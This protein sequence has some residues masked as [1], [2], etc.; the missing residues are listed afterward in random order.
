MLVVYGNAICGEYFDLVSAVVVIHD[1]LDINGFAQIGICGDQIVVLITQNGGTNQN[2]NAVGYA[3]EGHC[4]V[5]GTV[6]VIGGVNTFNSEILH[7]NGGVQSQLRIGE[8]AC[9]IFQFDVDGL[10]DEGVGIGKGVSGGMAIADLL[11]IAGV[12]PF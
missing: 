4:T 5:G 1:A 8:G 3:G 9:G 12:S 7:L 2:G 10:V 11:D 6:L